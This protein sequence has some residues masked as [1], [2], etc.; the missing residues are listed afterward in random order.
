MNSTGFY[1]EYL[2]GSYLACGIAATV[3]CGI[4]LGQTFHPLRA[5]YCEY[6]LVIHVVFTICFII[7]YW[8]H[9]IELGWLG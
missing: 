3:F 8:Y 7:M 6:F 4:I 2:K 9:C 5:I 1:T